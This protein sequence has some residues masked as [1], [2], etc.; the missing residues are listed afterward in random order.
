[1][2]VNFGICAVDNTSPTA[3]F[4]SVWT[5][6]FC[7]VRAT[8]TASNTPAGSFEIT[9]AAVTVSEVDFRVAGAFCAVATA[10]LVAS[11]ATVASVA[12]VATVCSVTADTFSALVVPSTNAATVSA[13][14]ALSVVAAAALSAVA[15]S[16]F[17][18][19]AAFSTAAASAAALSV[20]VALSDISPASV[21]AVG[22]VLVP[23]AL[24][25]VE[26][27]AAA[28]EVSN[29]R[30]SSF[31]T[32]VTTVVVMVVGRVGIPAVNGS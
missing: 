8:V 3:C 31:I 18:V 22:S 11:V 2:L 6:A 12:S 26:T 32:L 19:A 7:C 16:D 27:F 21:V 25:A 14:V 13:V 9:D 30:S 1:M 23:P 10:S 17:V 28:V 4:D 20:V 15:S 24:D 5:A 29:I